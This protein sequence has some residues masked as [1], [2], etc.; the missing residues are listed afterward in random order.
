VA[1]ALPEND[2]ISRGT[3]QGQAFPLGEAE[4]MVVRL[5]RDADGRVVVLQ[6]L[7]P[8]LTPEQQE[9]VRRAFAIGGFKRQNALPPQTDPWVETLTP[10]T[11]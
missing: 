3:V 11:Q 1:N 5:G 8:V 4:Q 9:E 7:S 6:V 2:P 10:N